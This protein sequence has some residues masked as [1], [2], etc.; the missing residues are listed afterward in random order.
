MITPHI[1]SACGAYA[2]GFYVILLILETWFVFR[3]H[4]AQS[5]ARASAAVDLSRRDARTFPNG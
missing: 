1:T 4:I 3:P 5:A 2:A